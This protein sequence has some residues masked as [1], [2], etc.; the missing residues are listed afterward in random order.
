MQSDE[1]KSLNIRL[2]IICLFALIAIFHIGNAFLAKSLY[3]P[4]HLSTALEYAEGPINLLQPVIQGFNANGTPTPQEFPVWQ[5]AAGL[6]FKIS[7]STWFG[8]ANL[9]SLGFFATALWPFWRLSREYVGDRAAD[10][11]LAFFLAEPVIVVYA[12]KAATDGFCLTVVI[13][14][15]FFADRMMRSGH[16]RWWP[17]LVVFACLSAVSKL[18]FY[19]VAGLVAAAMLVVRNER[20]WR[21]WLMLAGAG[22]V[23]VIVFI[24]WSHYCDS[25]AALAEYPYTELRVARNPFMVWWY[26][27]DLRMRLSPE[28]WIKGGWRFLAATLGSLPW[29]VILLAALSRPGNRLARLWLLA[30]LLMVLVFTHLV[31][32]HSHYYL[33]FCP[34]VAWLC[35]ATLSRWEMFWIQEIP[36][37]WLR[38]PLVLLMLVLSAVTGLIAMNIAMDYDSFPHKMSALIRQ[39][40]RPDDK[41]II[42]KADPEWPGELL[43]LSHRH[44]FYVPTLEATPGGPTPK[45]LRDILT[46][47]KDLK[48]LKSLGYNKLILVSES[49]LSFAVPASKPGSQRKRIYYPETVSPI[50]DAWPMIYRSEDLLIREIPDNRSLTNNIGI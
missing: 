38:L 10:W 16:W 39:Y 9:V 32:I 50:V 45:G 48:R 22:L 8:W 5:A 13:W 23:S 17:P 7:G 29:A 20:S 27:G 31:L 21:P 25:M 46:N 4:Q 36:H 30:G 14:F 1:N 42:F 19:M 34:A 26:F 41:V 2:L 35:G 12:G 40:T 49:P 18:P 47:P 3:R 43:F 28:M 44:G 11:T 24:W 37:R 6:A 15:L 33:I